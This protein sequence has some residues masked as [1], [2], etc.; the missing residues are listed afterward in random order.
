MRSDVAFDANVLLYLPSDDARS[1]R[2]VELLAEG[3]VVSPITLLEVARVARKKWRWDWVTTNDLLGTIRSCTLCLPVS[4]EAHDRGIA[5]AERYQLQV[6]DSVIIAAAVVAGC[7][8]LWSED[9]HHG[10]VVDGLTV[11]NP[12]R[13]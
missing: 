12:F 7:Q 1:E 2:S 13:G 9:M 6:I 3:G 10:L 11:R 4:C 5:Y 8:T